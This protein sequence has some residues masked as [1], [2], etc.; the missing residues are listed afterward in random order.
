MAT[1]DDMGLEQLLQQV[2][3]L[4]PSQV[5]DIISAPGQYQAPIKGNF[6]N[7]GG[8]SGAP[9]PRHPQG[10][11]GVDLRTAGGT[12]IYPMAPGTVTGVGSTPKGG[13]TVNIQHANGVRTYYAHM[14]TIQVQRGQ[15]V[16]ENTVI[17][18]VG[19]SGN[20]KGTWPH[21]HFQVWK[22]NQIQDPAQYFSIPKYSVPTSE[23]QQWLSSQHKQ[24]A[25][26][27]NMKRHL[28]NNRTAFSNRINRL[29]KLA[30]SYDQITKKL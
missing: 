25:Q 22:D 15:Q 4:I 29:V 21:V 16:G 2:K 24:N 1:D 30:R 17:G 27:F 12:A 19:D 18:T 20:A 28:D 11:A 3:Q 6:S 23:E 14:G 26:S 13:N 8:F 10:H 5:P 9:S 7:S